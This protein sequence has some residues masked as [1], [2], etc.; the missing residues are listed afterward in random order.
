M[1]ETAD[2]NKGASITPPRQSWK[3]D[4]REIASLGLSGSRINVIADKCKTSKRMIYYYFGDKEG[5]YRA[6]IESAY[7]E[8]RDAEQD[9]DLEHLEPMTALETLIEFTFHHHN[10][11]PDFIRLV[12][13][14]NI[15]HGEFLRHSDTIQA[16]NAPAI[17][18][19]ERIY[20]RG[21]EAGCFRAGLTPLELHWFISA[22]SFFNVSNRASFS[23]IFGDALTRDDS[24][25]VLAA[26]AREMI[27]RFVLTPELAC[28][29]ISGG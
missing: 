5:L 29:Y 8:V 16:L 9:L 24:Q 28:E 14:E 1:K 6:V 11:H 10:R 22:F 15:H 12:M 4:P 3:Q 17:N 2:A 20:Q 23:L 13:I 19:L 26:H 7:R 21:V 25:S 18:R 27:L